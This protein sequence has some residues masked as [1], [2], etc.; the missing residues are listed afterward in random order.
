[1]LD[2]S[3]HR[4]LHGRPDFY[5][6]IPDGLTFTHLNILPVVS[7]LLLAP[8]HDVSKTLQVIDIVFGLESVAAGFTLRQ[9]SPAD[10]IYSPVSCNILVLIQR[11]EIH[12][13]RMERKED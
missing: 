3:F 1:M 7:S 13:V 2:T 8:V 12:A 4:V 11:L 5:Q 6:I 9:G 10:A